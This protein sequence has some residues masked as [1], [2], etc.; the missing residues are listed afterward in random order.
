MIAIVDYGVGN[1]YSLSCSLRHI[2]AESIVTRD[3]DTL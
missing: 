2:G 3:A 1:L